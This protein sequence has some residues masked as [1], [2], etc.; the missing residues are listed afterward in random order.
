[1]GD[2]VRHPDWQVP[3]LLVI[4]AAIL[5]HTVY[6]ARA[7]LVTVETTAMSE[8]W[9][10]QFEDEATRLSILDDYRRRL[11]ETPALAFHLDGWIRAAVSHVTA[12]QGLTLMLAGL[13]WWAGHRTLP[14][15][16]GAMNLLFSMSLLALVWISYTLLGWLLADYPLLASF[17]TLIA[18]GLLLFPWLNALSFLGQDPEYGALLGVVAHGMMVWVPVHLIGTLVAAAHGG[19]L[20][21][22]DQVAPTSLGALFWAPGEGGALAALLQ[23]P[24][25]AWLWFWVLVVAGLRQLTGWDTTKIWVLA[26]S[27]WVAWTLITTVFSM[28]TAR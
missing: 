1:M 23:A 27:P 4:V 9:L 10:F 16:R 13:F 25:L 7:D 12:L 18:T 28:A 26:A 15:R 2:V 20:T 21:P 17:L 6:V 24:D 22:M 14:L 19:L 5:F 11:Q 8:A 3:L